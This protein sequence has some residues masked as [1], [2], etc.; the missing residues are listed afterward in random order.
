MILSREKTLI[1][2]AEVVSAGSDLAFSIIPDLGVK[3]YISHFHGSHSSSENATI[4]AVWR[5]GELDEQIIDVAN[6]GVKKLVATGDGE[7]KI[8]LVFSNTEVSDDLA[9]SGSMLVTEETN[10]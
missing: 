9:F 4:S 7:S 2:A 6:T 5:Y 8:A 3:V 1:E 10:V